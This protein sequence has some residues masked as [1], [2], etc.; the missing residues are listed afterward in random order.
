LSWLWCSG[1]ESHQRREDYR[2]H[3]RDWEGLCDLV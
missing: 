3:L 1:S 2:F